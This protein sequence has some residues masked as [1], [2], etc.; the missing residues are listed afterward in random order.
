[1]RAIV[2][3]VYLF[4]TFLRVFTDCLKLY[5][6]VTCFCAAEIRGTY[7]PDVARLPIFGRE[8]KLADLQN[9]LRLLALHAFHVLDGFR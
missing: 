3:D 6:A 2:P 9:M 4:M 1:M 8:I 7:F 5:K